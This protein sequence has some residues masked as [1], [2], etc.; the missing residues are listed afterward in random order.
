MA[1]D[2]RG[3]WLTLAMII[4][5]TW[6]ILIYGVRMWAKLRVKSVGAD[7]WVVTLALILSIVHQGIMHSA[8]CLGYGKRSESLSAAR[9][10]N[11]NKHIY[12]SHYFY[13]IASGLTRVAAAFFIEQLSQHGPH[14]RPARVLAWVSGTWT[15]I[16]LGVIVV[17]PPYTE[18]WLSVDGG[19]IVFRRWSGIE[20]SGLVLSAALWGL[21]V[22]LIWTL[23]MRLSRR[24]VI[25]LVFGFRLLTVPIIFLRVH[26][27]VPNVNPD[28]NYSTI[29]AAIFTAAA[30]QFSVISTSLTALKPF[31]RVFRPPVLASV[32]G[33][34]AGETDHGLA[35]FRRV[36]RNSH[37]RS[38]ESA[39]D[40]W[41]KTVGL[42]PPGRAV[43]RRRDE[44]RP[45]YG[46]A[47]KPPCGTSRVQ[48]RQ[49]AAMDLPALAPAPAD[50]KPGQSKRIMGFSCQAC[51]RRKVKC[52]KTIP[53]CAACRRTG[54]A[55]VYE[56]PAPRGGKRLVT[57]DVL[58]KLARYEQVLKRHG[59]LDAADSG[60]VSSS[61]DP[62]AEPISIHWDAAGGREG[63]AVIAEEGRARYVDGGF[64][65][66]IG[67]G[68]EQ[69][70]SDEEDHYIATRL[71]SLAVSDPLSDALLGT[72]RQAL[73]SLHPTPETAMLLW[74]A[75]ADN[76]EPIV[77]ILHVPSA[78]AVF[79]RTARLP[80]LARP[81]DECLA[82][83]V[84]HFAVF[85]MTEQACLEQL[86]QPRATLL[87]S[88]HLAARQALVNARLLETT[89]LTVLQA[90][91]LLLLPPP[92]RPEAHWI[93]TG[94]A[95]RIGQRIGLHRDGAALGLAPFET[96]MR[97]RLFY[98]LLSLDGSAAQMAG[99][100]VS[101]PPAWDVRP[102]LNVD[103][104]QLWPSMRA[105]PAERRGAT[106]MI[107]RLSRTCIGAAF[108]KTGSARFAEAQHAEA[109][110]A[111]AEREVEE[112]YLRYCDVVNPLHFLSA[113][114]ARSGILAMRLRVRLSKI[115]NETATDEDRREALRL[116]LRILGTDDAVC[117]HEPAARFRWHTQRSF[118]LWG[119]WDALAFA[120]NGPRTGDF[121]E[122]EVDEAWERV[123]RVYANHEELLASRQP[124]HAA[125]CKL[126]L[127]AWE[128][129]QRRR[130]G[131]TETEPAF[132]A[133]LWAEQEERR[134]RR[135]TRAAGS[136]GIFSEVDADIMS[137]S[138]GASSSESPFDINID[139]ADWAFWDGLLR[140]GM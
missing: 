128:E 43:V 81:A 99:L 22:H 100:A 83:S 60:V 49:A 6:S 117:A 20:C 62:A 112:R 17:R 12:A 137:C 119:T 86:R 122:T 47:N 104:D 107:F 24:I 15:L 64:W 44:G 138:G 51:G 118:F 27:L 67:V 61:G 30:L 113:A 16:C 134:Q 9:L 79:E 93:L 74:Q 68:E 54:V 120:L 102:P 77:K 71:Q 11:I 18:P 115:R 111:E 124:M 36:D 131:E 85:S 31:L 110:I 98:P 94:A 132:V 8:V 126:T 53:A 97:R 84:Y 21:T 69:L 23:Q 87:S 82:F 28:P 19:W 116:A 39:T 135:E 57:R 88:F 35:M 7:D 29:P 41:G 32:T 123:E 89:D 140:G 121:S 125:L 33:R 106:E 42:P 25:L 70:V 139:D 63:G 52:D 129:R 90:F 109:A 56:A 75:Y 66:T 5:L 3:S 37:Q 10:D 58:D 48:R 4:F 14:A 78:R 105:A 127:V 2:D 34:A 72:P 136:S 55:C 130:E 76:V 133:A 50:R 46:S 65:R 13:I 45:Y 91:V 114:L 103:D 26:S 73:D 40:L 101:P 96:E 38:D 1:G 95:S 59:L 80:H 92:S 108:A